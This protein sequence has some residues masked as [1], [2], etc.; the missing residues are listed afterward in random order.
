MAATDVELPL[1]DGPWD[2]MLDSISPTAKNTGKYLLG[3]NV[4]PLDPDLGD[5]MVGRPGVRQMG[6]QLAGRV[7]G[8]YQFKKSTG[9]TYTV[10]V[11]GGKFYT[12]DWPNELWTEIVTTAQLL[13]AGIVLDAVNKVAFLTTSDER[14]F[15]SDGIHKPWLWDGTAGGGVTYLANAEPMYGQP[16]L[17]YARVIGIVAGEPSAIIWSETDD[18]ATGYRSGGFNNVW[19]PTQ[20]DP[21]RLYSII[22]TNSVIYAS[23]A[24]STLPLEGPPGPGFSTDNTRDSI[25]DTIGTLAPFATVLHDVNLLTL[26]ADMHPQFMRP[27]GAGF[28]PLWRELRQTTRQLSKDPNLMQK[29][30]TVFY[31]PASLFLIAVPDSGQAECNMLL[32]YDA[33]GELPRAVAIW[34]GWE[35]TSLA[36]V[37]NPNGQPYLF[38]G[39]STGRVYLHGNPDDAAPWDDF[40]ASGTVAIE[41]ILEQQPQGYSTKKEK[42]YDRIDLALRGLNQM[43]LLVSAV[44]P[45]GASAEQQI[46]VGQNFQ[47]FDVILFDV[48]LF[49]PGGTTTQETHGDCGIDLEGRWIKTKV[50][51]QTLGEQFGI[52][53]ITVAAYTTDDDPEAP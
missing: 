49:D 17:S 20:N 3:Q 34:R 19:A 10:A 7:Q 2:G 12:L 27:G 1:E 53:A 23:R 41:H 28:I 25:S 48:G 16:R 32:V 31:E 14:L 43:T 13:A 44:T 51:H 5:E 26:D 8:K 37:E 15:V 35:M 21:N 29:C 30:M 6:Q 18:P 52:G 36:M 50:R 47:G 42:V 39:D 40:M 11:A 9:Q 45:Q 24:R 46:V 22:A 4:Y 33:K 38:H